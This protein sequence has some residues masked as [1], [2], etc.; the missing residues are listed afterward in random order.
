MVHSKYEELILVRIGGAESILPET[1]HR[2]S[3]TA[4]LTN[5]KSRS[6]DNDF[7]GN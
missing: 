3:M 5:L 6:A 2:R 1:E 4:N 7:G